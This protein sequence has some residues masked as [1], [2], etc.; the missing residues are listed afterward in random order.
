M[1]IASDPS[2]DPADYEF[3]HQVRVRFAE[4]D[5]M[6]IV[7]HSRYLPMLEEAR[8]AYLR[9]IGHPYQSIRDE[10]IDIAV[11]EAFL[12][13][14]QPLRFDEVVDVHVSIAEIG[15]AT[16]QMAYAMTVDGDLRATGVTA[17]GCITPDG[18]P[19][20]LPGWFRELRSLPA[21]TETHP[22]PV[23]IGNGRIT[24]EV[25]PEHGGR[26]GQIT[27]DGVDLL[28]GEG[29]GRPDPDSPLSWGSYPMVPWAGRI[30][31]G[32]FTFD[33][34]SHQL[35]IN[36]ETHAIHG[37]GFSS[38]WSVRDTAPD[39]VSLELEM[40][41]GA[42]W[43]FGG[44][45]RQTISVT[46][47]TVRMELSVTAVDRAMPAAIGWHPWFRK[48]SHVDFRP[49]AMYRRDDEWITV[50][51][52]L[53][54]PG[55]PWDDCFVNGD[56]VRLTVEGVELVLRSDCTEWVVFDMLPHGTCV[57]PQTAPPD[58]FTVRPNRLEPGDTL[59]AWYEIS[60]GAGRSADRPA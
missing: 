52:L 48:P 12:Q 6:G 10:G 33:G 38:A 5:A 55:P 50:D 23:R 41:E 18:R 9:H 57:E 20:R 13:Y 2:T 51:E 58:A 54:P 22:A 42:A 7:H 60:A 17:H 25:R 43:P 8:V 16:F 56:P 29:E 49:S 32:R 28:V 24:V 3:H 53:P 36:F 45:A 46:D 1:R 26:V 11:L 19:T 15:R 21:P 4:T 39:R 40:P 44:I 30:R 59:S 47:E 35:P 14:R 27:V 31:S 37:V 34:E